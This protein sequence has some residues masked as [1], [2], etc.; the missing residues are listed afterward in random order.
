MI[1]TH[2]GIQ[3]LGA[4]KT[5]ALQEK[6]SIIQPGIKLLGTEFI[7]FAD[8][9]EDM[10]EEDISHLNNLLNYLLLLL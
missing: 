9:I 8:L 7:H 4:F 3:A 2:R 5:K 6:I 1:H 10:S